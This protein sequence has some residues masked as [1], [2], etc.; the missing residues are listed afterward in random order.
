MRSWPLR[1][2][3][4]DDLTILEIVPRNSPPVMNFLVND[5]YSYA[6]EH[7]M[8]LNPTKCKC[9]VDFLD[10]NTC[11]WSPIFI[12]NTVVER[13]RTFKLLGITIA[14]YL[15]WDSHFDI[16]VWKANKRLHALRQLK[17]CGVSDQDII[18]VYG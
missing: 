8:M 7:K 16:I 4:V 18:L 6:S 15:K 14:D 3:F 10:Y 17:K 9:I 13:V 11:T 1:A 12:G 2:K 5:V